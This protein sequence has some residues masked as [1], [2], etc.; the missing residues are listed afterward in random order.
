MARRQTVMISGA[1]S[2]I[3]EALAGQFARAGYDL[4]LVAR[5]E[6]RLLQLAKTLKAEHSVNV[7]VEAIDLAKR[8]AARTLS[9]RMTQRSIEIDILVNNAG[10]LEYGN[11]VDISHTDHQRI[12]DLNIL[13]LTSMLDYFLPPMIARQRGKVL[14][15]ASIA[16]FQPV[17]AWRLT[18]PAR[19]TSCR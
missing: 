7:A 11:F 10:V 19:P 4:V 17:R 6:A 12:I 2:G 14:N 8:S 15:V 13:G 16:A 3:G 9:N 5:N 18:P 1:S